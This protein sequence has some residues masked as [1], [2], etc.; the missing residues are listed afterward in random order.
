MVFLILFNGISSNGF[1]GIKTFF[2][3]FG[4]SLLTSFGAS[5]TGFLAY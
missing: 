3:F 1:S 2:G 5:T 4:A